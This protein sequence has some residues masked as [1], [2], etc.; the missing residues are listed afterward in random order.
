MP[1]VISNQVYK[2]ISPFGMIGY[3]EHP[4]QS[5]SLLIRAGILT[6]GQGSFNVNAVKFN[7]GGFVE[8]GTIEIVSVVHYSR[9][10]FTS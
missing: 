6:I 10:A 1:N 9:M 7:A 2:L 4:M 5:P 8:K 3:M